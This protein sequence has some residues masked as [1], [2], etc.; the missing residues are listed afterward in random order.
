[1]TNINTNSNSE[2]ILNKNLTNDT[3]N[4]STDTD[5]SNK[6]WVLPTLVPSQSLIGKVG[7]ASEPKD[8]GTI[9][10]FKYERNKEGFL[11][12]VEYDCPLT[13]WGTLRRTRFVRDLY[14]KYIL[15]ENGCRVVAEYDHPRDE[16]G[17]LVSICPEMEA[18]KKSRSVET[19]V[20]IA[21]A[22]QG[23]KKNYIS[24]LKGLT[25]EAHPSYKHGQG[26]N[27]NYDHQKYSAWIQGV[28]HK[29]NY[30]CIVTGETSE[31]ACHHLEAWSVSE[32]GRYDINN[33][34]ALKKEIHN[35]FHTIYGS[36]TT[37]A[38]F[39]KYL[40]EK[41]NW[42]DKPFPWRQGNHEP[43][44]SVEQIAEKQLNLREL[45]YKEFV[46]LC[47]SRNHEVLSGEYINAQSKVNVKCNIHNKTIETTFTNYKKCKTGL[48]CCGHGAQVQKALDRY[49]K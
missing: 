33:G 32:A 34:V 12:E 36:K 17:R 15:D 45:K 40:Q 20:A 42:G 19:R 44:L 48:R 39:E 10:M 27:R 43:S 11:M 26:K 13:S 37:T 3:T 14:G 49:S 21:L 6:V 47:E 41:H 9:K 46:E 22:H 28:L 1:M 29:C 24:Y 23:V 4:T 16:R 30:Q 38:M 7:D 25:G 8:Y 5:I 2:N 18:D 35:G 31:L